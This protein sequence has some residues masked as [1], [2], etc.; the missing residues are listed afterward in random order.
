MLP[1]PI[2]PFYSLKLDV[3]TKNMT[4]RQCTCIWEIPTALVNWNNHDE[5]LKNAINALY[6]GH[7]LYCCCFECL[8][9]LKLRDEISVAVLVAIV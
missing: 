3:A 4:S 5:A 8:S 9:S 7:V 2:F 1:K 6:K